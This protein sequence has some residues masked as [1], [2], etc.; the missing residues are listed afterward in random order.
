MESLDGKVAWI[1]GA[2]TG[3]GAVTAIALA[4]AGMRVVISGRR[5]EALEDTAVS[6]RDAGGDVTVE[7]LDV[8]DRAAMLAVAKRIDGAFGRLDLQF[9]NAGTN[10]TKRSWAEAMADPGLLDGWDQVIDANVKG[11]YNGI[12]AALPIMRRQGEGLIITTASWAGRFYSDVA[13]SAYGASKHAVMALNATLKKEEGNNGIRATAIC[14]GEV[15]T[16]ILDRRPKKL[17]P[18]ELAR[19][20]QPEDVAELVVFLARLNPRTCINEVLMSPT[21]DRFQA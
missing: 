10:V 18:E 13:G 19:V 9:N 15:A 8:A 2:G 1:T 20:I 7:A 4:G 11:V 16:P 21:Y 6:I 12:V 3:I 17:T 14:P 5:P